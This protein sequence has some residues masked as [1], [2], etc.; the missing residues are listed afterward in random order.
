MKSKWKPWNLLCSFR[1]GPYPTLKEEV[2][3]SCSKTST[4]SLWSASRLFTRSRP[5]KLFKCKCSPSLWLLLLVPIAHVSIVSTPLG[6]N[7]VSGDEP[8]QNQTGVQLH[9]WMA[10]CQMLAGPINEGLQLTCRVHHAKCQ[11]GWIT[12]WNQG[13]WEKYQLSQIC[14]WHHP[15]S[16]KQRGA[17]EPLDE[18][19]RGEWKSWHKIQHSKTKTMASGL[20]TS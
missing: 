18:G 6:P 19:E 15:Y 13:C 14:K 17:K 20:I 2:N 12:S 3:N 10:E 9:P 8:T 5:F 11:A 7:T 4:V 1:A 16:R